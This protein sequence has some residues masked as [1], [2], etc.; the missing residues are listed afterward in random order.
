MFG[1]FK[2]SPVV[3]GGYL[4]KV[5]PRLSG[6]QKYR[7][8]NRMKQVDQN[9][10]NIY[11]A[12]VA[13]EGK[14]QGES[15]GYAKIDHLKFSMPKESEMA[16]RDKYTTFTKHSKTYRKDLHLVPKWTKKSFRENPKYY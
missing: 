10:E 14:K 8:R 2:S 1:A 11:T 5:A 6:P 4:W 9:I 12:L 13:H 16:P 15:T 7:L 3:S